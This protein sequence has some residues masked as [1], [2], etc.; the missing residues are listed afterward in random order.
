MPFEQKHACKTRVLEN[1]VKDNHDTAPKR[2][3][4]ILLLVRHRH[5][6]C[7]V[8]YTEL[9]GLVPC[10]YRS[11]T[12]SVHYTK[13]LHC[14]LCYLSYISDVSFPDWNV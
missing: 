6:P 5:G 10:S 1:V 3:V 4:Y 2:V 9:R 11:S 7:H 12:E 13:P 8:L 14:G